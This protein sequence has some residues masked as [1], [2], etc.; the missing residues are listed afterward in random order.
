MT[1]SRKRMLLSSIAML[2][3]ALVALGSATYAWFTVSKTVTADGMQVKAIA[4]AGLQICN[5]NNGGGTYDTTVSFGQ[6]S[7]GY[8]LLPVSYNGTSDNQ[9]FV[10]AENVTDATDGRYTGSFKATGD[11]IPTP[12]VADGLVM[13]K[14][15]KSY[16]AVYKV[17][18][19]SA[20]TSGDGETF[21][22]PA[23]TVNAKVTISGDNATFCRAQLFD[24]TTS[25]GIYGDSSSAG[26]AKVITAAGAKP[27]TM[28]TYAVT[29]CPDTATGWEDTTGWMSPICPS[30]LR[31]P[32][33]RQGTILTVPSQWRLIKIIRNRLIL[34]AII[35]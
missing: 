18:V 8:S 15:G 13:A 24:G 34:K 4:Q 11:T 26:N 3:V 14:S 30:R 33:S 32:I 19:R 20:P 12:S 10:P 7:A 22:S 29:A 9:G 35:W 25:K 17:W 5:T 28:P 16:F 1:K 31:F 21:A 2:L 23:H 27:E 6:S